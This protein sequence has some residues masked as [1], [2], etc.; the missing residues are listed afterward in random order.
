M[1]GETDLDRNTPAKRQGQPLDQFFV[2]HDP[3][4]PAGNIL[5]GR[6]DD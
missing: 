3:K 2:R 1:R 6:K 5:S 4:S